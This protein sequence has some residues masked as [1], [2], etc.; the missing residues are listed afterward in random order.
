MESQEKNTP[1]MAAGE[2]KINEYINRIKA[3][4]PK[5]EIMQGLPDSFKDAIE[6]GLNPEKKQEEQILSSQ[7]SMMVIPA[8][9]KGLDAESLDFIWTVPEYVD[10]EKTKKEQE[11]KAKALA[12]L[13]EQEKAQM[14]VGEKKIQEKIQIEKLRQELR[15]PE[16]PVSIEKGIENVSLEYMS[17][18][19]FAEYLKENLGDILRE[20][21]AVKKNNEHTLKLWL[22]NSLYGLLTVRPQKRQHALEA[23]IGKVTEEDNVPQEKWMPYLGKIKSIKDKFDNTDYSGAW[24]QFNFGNRKNTEGDGKRRKGYLTITEKSVEAYAQKVDSIMEEANQELKAVGYNGS[25]KI[26]NNL[27]QLT[28]Q[29]DSIVAH[30]ANFDEVT[31]ALDILKNVLTKNGVEVESEQRGM[32]EK[33]L[34]DP[35]ENASHTQL[36]AEKITLGLRIKET[37]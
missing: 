23:F 29:F 25:F 8:Q 11:R 31:K 9:Y 37:K 24:L 15:A 6:K 27:K 30:G 28:N 34:I 5:D 21:E 19:D 2:Q 17:Q 18:E 7:E 32:D 12:S 4:E 26:S 36:L 22:K 35:T 13:R 10:P 16:K 3:G 14:D 1:E 20:R 33:G